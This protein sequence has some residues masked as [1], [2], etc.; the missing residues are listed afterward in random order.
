MGAGVKI[1]SREKEKKTHE[2]GNGCTSDRTGC[3]DWQL[4]ARVG[5]NSFKWARSSLETRYSLWAKL[6]ATKGRKWPLGS[7]LPKPFL[8][9]SF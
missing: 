7:D 5:L 1:M 3:C 9:R 4:Q 8:K 6:G 2:E